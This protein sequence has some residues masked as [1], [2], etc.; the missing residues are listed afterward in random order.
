MKGEFEVES[1]AIL[2]VIRIPMNSKFR[3]NIF[4]LISIKINSGLHHIFKRG[5]CVHVRACVCVHACVRACM[6]AC[7]HVCVRAYM[8]ECVQV[9]TLHEY[10]LY[11]Y[12]YKQGGTHKHNYA[13]N[14]I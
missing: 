2:Y 13:Q 14:D 11:K 5:Q 7:M 10:P 1:I 3:Q 9:C 12:K 6:R 4:C 8:P